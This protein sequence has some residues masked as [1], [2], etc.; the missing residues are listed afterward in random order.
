MR[1]GPTTEL[2]QRIELI[3]GAPLTNPSGSWHGERGWAIPGLCERWHCNNRTVM[4]LMKW[5]GV[6]PE[7]PASAS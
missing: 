3:E 7:R 2:I 5:F 6:K 1:P 4:R